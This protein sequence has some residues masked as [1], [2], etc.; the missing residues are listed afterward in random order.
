MALFPQPGIEA[1]DERRAD[2]GQGKV[3]V[4]FGPN[5][6]NNW[7]WCIPRNETDYNKG[8]SSTANQ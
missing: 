7:T 3:A 4:S 8:I 1:A 2:A 6:K 5:E